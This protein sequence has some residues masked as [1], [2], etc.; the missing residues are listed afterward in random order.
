MARVVQAR[1][2]RTRETILIAAEALIA[3]QGLGSLTMDAVAA[4]AAVSKG[5]L[6]HHFRSKEALIAGL[7][8]RKID[9]IKNDTACEERSLGDHSERAV[10]GMIRHSVRQYGDEEGFPPALLVAATQDSDCVS[11]I[12]GM[13]REK[14][15]RIQT[16]SSRPDEAGMLLFAALG[17]VLSRALGLS[18]LSDDDAGRIFEA[19]ELYV[20]RMER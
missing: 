18:D 17:L 12:R 8:S 3:R 11:Q 13:L 4:E 7:V 14:L 2:L 16:E 1:S 10:L 19:M 9:A 15:N 5:G 20:R 6:Q